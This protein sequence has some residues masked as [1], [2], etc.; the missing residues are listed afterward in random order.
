M[1]FLWGCLISLALVYIYYRISIRPFLVIETMFPGPFAY[2]ILGNALS[3]MMSSSEGM[4]MQRVIE[5]T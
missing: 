2:P 4:N 5:S 3:I 1:I